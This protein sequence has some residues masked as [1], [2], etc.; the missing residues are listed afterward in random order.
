MGVISEEE[1]E[2]LKLEEEA[3]RAQGIKDITG[4]YGPGGTASQRA[5]NALNA[6]SEQDQKLGKTSADLAKI[7]KGKPLSADGHAA[8]E[9]QIKQQIQV[10]MTHEGSIKQA[11]A[12]KTGQDIQFQNQQMANQH[13]Q[14]MESNTK[15]G[16]NKQAST[17]QMQAAGATDA[18]Q[19]QH[20]TQ[21]AG[22][23]EASTKTTVQLTLATKWQDRTR[24]RPR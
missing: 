6:V 21:M 5:S 12:E 10:V 7:G 13:E 4:G 9:K 8:A 18:A 1:K 3:A 19:K 20:E 17:Q 2:R 22:Q 11:I 24:H 15:E 23:N 16:A 14:T